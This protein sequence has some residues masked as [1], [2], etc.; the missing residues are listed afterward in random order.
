MESPDSNER[1]LTTFNV[2]IQ[3]IPGIFS[4]SVIFSQEVFSNATRP[5]ASDNG[6]L[7]EYGYTELEI[8]W[9]AEENYWSVPALLKFT[10]LPNF[11]LGFL[12]SG[13]VMNEEQLLQKFEER[14]QA[15]EIIEPE[16][17][18]PERYRKQLIRMMSQHAHSEIALELIIN[19]ES[20]L[21]LKTGMHTKL[22]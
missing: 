1:S 17:W 10:A 14:I 4:S 7:T 9:T 16:D 3:D 20:S 18:M 5:S 6:Y 15:G 19:I 21:N 8:G 22:K 13:I 2:F 11:E 12:M